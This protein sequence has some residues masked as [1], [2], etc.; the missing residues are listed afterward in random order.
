MLKNWD[1]EPRQAATEIIIR[2]KNHVEL[3]QVK[4]IS[5]R[6]DKF[7]SKGLNPNLLP[8]QEHQKK[9]AKQKKFQ[10]ILLCQN[11]TFCTSSQRWTNIYSCCARR[12]LTRNFN[13]LW[14]KTAP[15]ERVS[16]WTTF[17]QNTQAQHRH[18]GPKYLV[19]LYQRDQVV[20]PEFRPN[21]TKK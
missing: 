11:V 6:I 4:N 3:S 13:M 2:H 12:S 7:A 14:V 15:T 10:S 16:Y 1:V 8:R 9:F 20:V 21:F 17:L 19:T 18:L 5:L